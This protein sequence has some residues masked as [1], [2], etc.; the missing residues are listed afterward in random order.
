MDRGAAPRHCTAGGRAPAPTR[1]RRIT[2]LPDRC[3]ACTPNKHLDHADH[4]I[5]AKRPHLRSTRPGFRLP[6]NLAPGPR[7]AKAPRR[8]Q[9]HCPPVPLPRLPHPDPVD[10]VNRHG[11][12]SSLTWRARCGENRTLGFGWPYTRRGDKFVTV[13]LDLTRIRE[14]GPARSLN[15]VERPSKQAFLQWPAERPDRWRPTWKSSRWTVHRVQDR[16]QPGTARRDGGD[17]P[18]SR[19]PPPRRH[20]GPLP[21]PA[22]TS[23][24]ALTAA[25]KMI[26]S[27][28][29]GAPCTPGRSAHRPAEHAD[30]RPVRRRTTRR[31]RG[32]L[33][34]LPADG[35]RLP[36]WR[37]SAWPGRAPRPDRHGEPGVPAGLREVITPSAPR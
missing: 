36:R 22:S 19:G 15:M 3:D 6:R 2:D 31:G 11:A 25:A 9:R 14:G 37:P 34:C 16:H 12:T 4:V 27:T 8:C 7:P 28:G 33:G 18:I 35:R 17:A 23:R 24:S 1:R 13:I 21:P 29:R 32:H 26:G 20:T 10:T 5:D 30:H